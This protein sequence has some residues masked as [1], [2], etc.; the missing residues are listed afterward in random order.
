[1]HNKKIFILLPDGIGLRNFAF[2]NF[3][4]LGLEKEYDITF[5]NNTQFEL[6]KLGIKEI[7]IKNAKAHPITDLLKTAQTHIELSQSI[8]KSK[9]KVY[10]SYRFPLSRRDMKVA[11]K[12]TMIK[13][14][15]LWN[16]SQKGLKNIR[17]AIAKNER[18]TKLYFDCFETLQK[19]KPAII[20]CTNQRIMLA[21][22]PILA[23]QDLG[24]P[25]ATFIFS[26]DNLPKGTKILETDFYFVWS[27]HMKSEL[28]NYYPHIS[29]EQIKIT[30]TTQFEPH[31]QENLLVSKVA[32][33]KEHKLDTTKKYICYSG[34]DITTS[35]NDPIYLADLAKAIVILN[36]KGANLAIIFRRCPVDFSN[37][38]DEILAEFKAIITSINPKWEKKGNSWHSILP[39]KEDMVLQVNTIFHSEL[40]INLGSSMVF[41]YVTFAK[42]CGFINYDV[43]NIDYPN[44]SVKKIYKFIH[45]RSM[46]SKDSV[47]WINSPDE[48]KQI[49]EKMLSNNAAK[50]VENA[51]KW[52]EKI[53]QH[54]PQLASERIWN[55]LEEICKNNA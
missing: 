17:A 54:P 49:V 5:W 34:D 21:V 46:P 45:F 19:E 9:D 47:F 22:A 29:E 28:L 39:T 8:K 12:S 30:G 16:N 48:M 33:F 3:H 43:P 6:S 26:W 53:N 55:A 40:V 37:R 36:E 35:P 13:A 10:N 18:K 24:I 23:A 20:F 11:V 51:Q 2:T 14:I 38:F 7:I 42:P 1:M 31:F 52:F 41:D 25:T 44:W 32:F 50:V 15:I 4:K 27:E